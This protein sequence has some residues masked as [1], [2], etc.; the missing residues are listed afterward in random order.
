VED[1]E[2]RVLGADGHS[3]WAYEQVAQGISVRLQSRLGLSEGG[4]SGVMRLV[5]TKG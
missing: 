3:S 5:A 1:K 2:A 4:D